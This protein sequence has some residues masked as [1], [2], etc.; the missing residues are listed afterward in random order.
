ML[1]EE[2]IST[3]DSGRVGREM[4]Q[5]VCPQ[6]MG[7]EVSMFLYGICESRGEVGWVG[8][9][10]RVTVII[11]PKNGVANG[12]WTDRD[13]RENHIQLFCSWN[14]NVFPLGF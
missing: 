10:D 14:Y 1:I 9:M 11:R 7:K 3:T 5:L 8:V 12:D 2:A 13:K 6:S 4:N